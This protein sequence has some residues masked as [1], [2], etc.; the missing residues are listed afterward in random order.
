MNLCESYIQSSSVYNPGHV[1]I[2]APTDDA[3]IA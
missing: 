2:M 3:V 1:V